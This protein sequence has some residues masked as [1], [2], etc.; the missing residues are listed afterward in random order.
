MNVNSICTF[1]VKEI[2]REYLI[3]TRLSRS[4]V[5]VKRTSFFADL[6]CKY[7]VQHSLMLLNTQLEFSKSK[8]KKKCRHLSEKRRVDTTA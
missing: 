5:L 1:G 7:G 4:F 2:C 8:I 6:N 3:I